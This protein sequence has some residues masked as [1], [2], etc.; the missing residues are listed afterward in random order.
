MMGSGEFRNEEML[1]L[2]SEDS[3]W[4]QQKKAEGLALIYG[5]QMSHLIIN[6]TDRAEISVS[7]TQQCQQNPQVK[8]LKT[9]SLWVC[10]T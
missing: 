2:A 7:L 4:A 5:H 9:P 3:L 8:Q 6:F 1:D 10:N